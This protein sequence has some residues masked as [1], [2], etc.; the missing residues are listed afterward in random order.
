MFP[1]VMP[2]AKRGKSGTMIT[3]VKL[4]PCVRLCVC[5]YVTSD[6]CR[7][8]T[9]HFCERVWLWRVC[10]CV[11]GGVHVFEPTCKISCCQQC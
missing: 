7:L 5:A 9:S 6:L 8:Q 2:A 10:M 11:C 3:R 1:L 4:P